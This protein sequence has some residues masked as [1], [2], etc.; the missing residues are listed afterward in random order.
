MSK[1][2]GTM[3]V[4]KVAAAAHAT[5]RTLERKFRKSTGHTVK[6]V[7]GLMRFEQVRNQLWIDP[8][9]NLAERSLLVFGEENRPP[10]WG[11]T[12]YIGLRDHLISPFLTGYEGTGLNSPFPTNTELFRKARVQG[13]ATGYV[14]AFGGESDPLKGK[15][16]G[17][18]KGYAVDVALGTIDA[19]ERSAASRGSAPCRPT[20]FSS[21]AARHLTPFA[22]SRSHGAPV[23]FSTRA[24]QCGW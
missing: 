17:G 13:A 14:H 11:H 8:A 24:D 22:C 6:D 2:N 7:S 15:G 16:I 12:F 9:S 1:A 19:L 3:P 21:R 5:V 20:R 18:A 10:F 23:R 4:N